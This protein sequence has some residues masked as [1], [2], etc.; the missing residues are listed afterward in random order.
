MSRNYKKGDRVQVRTDLGGYTAKFDHYT[1][2]S[3]K[4][5]VITE[6]LGKAV[7]V[8]VDRLHWAKEKGKY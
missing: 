6:M 2:F 7:L 8:D 3:D 5:Y 1:E 4:V